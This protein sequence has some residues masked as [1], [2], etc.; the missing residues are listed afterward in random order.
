RL[1]SQDVNDYL[2]SSAQSGGGVL[3]MTDGEKVLRERAAA[4][5][6]YWRMAAGVVNGRDLWQSFLS[7]NH[8]SEST[9]HEE[10]VLAAEASLNAVL[11][12]GPPDDTWAQGAKVLADAYASE[13]RRITR[14]LKSDAAATYHPRQSPCPA[15]A[16]KTSGKETPVIGPIEHSLDE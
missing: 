15:A 5:Q 7:H 9:P 11:A 12:R 4:L 8:L 3:K 6:K 1:F 14:T 13:R 10:A 16:Q 2:I